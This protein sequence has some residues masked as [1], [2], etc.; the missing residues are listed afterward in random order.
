MLETT[1]CERCEWEVA[2]ELMPLTECLTTTLD[3]AIYKLRKMTVRL[4]VD[5]VTTECRLAERKICAKIVQSVKSSRWNCV[6][7]NSLL[8]YVMLQASRCVTKYSS[9]LSWVHDHLGLKLDL[10]PKTATKTLRNNYSLQSSRHQNKISKRA[11]ILRMFWGWKR[12][13]S[14][15]CRKANRARVSIATVIFLFC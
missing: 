2:T 13:F 5:A 10:Q 12:N 9:P 1:R 4:T 15:A 6:K 11:I 7:F 3:Y 8:S 14:A